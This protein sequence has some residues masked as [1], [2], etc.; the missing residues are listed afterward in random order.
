MFA[1]EPA[2]SVLKP[3]LQR[4]LALANGAGPDAE[5][6]IPQQQCLNAVKKTYA[7]DN[8]RYACP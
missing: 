3:G 7:E 1:G 2:D 8:R 6:H 4:D 5:S